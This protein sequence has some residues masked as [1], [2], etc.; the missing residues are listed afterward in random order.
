M[1]VLLQALGLVCLG[2]VQSTGV[3]PSKLSSRERLS[4][5]HW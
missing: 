2:E 5:V 3:V 4:S 1:F